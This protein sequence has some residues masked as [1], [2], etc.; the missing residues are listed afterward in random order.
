[1]KKKLLAGVLTAA[2]CAAL[3]TGCGNSKTNTTDTE[4]K[5]TDTAAGIEAD[6]GQVTL[7]VWAEASNFDVLNQMFES[8]KQEYA[9]QATFDIQLE[10]Y[11]DSETK[12]NVLGDVHNAAD[13]FP[14]AD[15]MLDGMVAGGAVCAVPNAD[16]ISARN[17]EDAINAASVNGVLYAYPYSADNGFFLF[18]NKEY[19]SESDVQTWD[20]VLKVAEENGKKVY[21]DWSSGWYT[22]AFW[23]NTGL[24]F[25]INDDGVTNYC[26]WN[27][28]DTDITGVDVAEAMLATA[29]SP[30]FLNC[31]DDVFIEEMNA[32]NAIA[33]VSGVWDTTAV[34]AAWGEDY[35]AVKLPTYTVAGKQVQMASFKGYKM[36]GVNPYSE[37]LAWAQ[38]LADWITNEENQLLRLEAM[39]Q[40]PSNINAAASDAVSSIPS[41]KAV[42]DQAEFGVLQRVGNS[43]WTATSEF[44]LKM[45]DGN[46]KGEDLQELLDAMVAEITASVAN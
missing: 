25:G 42:Q 23:G 38:K 5:A 28:T 36:Y 15:D 7:R 43:Y 31:T 2:L 10:E 35:G 27:A 4:D 34:E 14:M 8:F 24:E 1:M 13:V 11:T 20:Q 6:N 16:E 22:Y 3:M 30:A 32:G 18:Y 33:G 37:H 40:G 21:M 19:Y 41:I 39:S 29:S 17:L 45:A 9:G 26:N 46:P 44:G 12:N